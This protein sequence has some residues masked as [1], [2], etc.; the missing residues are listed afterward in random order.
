MH[1]RKHIVLLTIWFPPL[2]SVAVNRM[3]AF[4]RYL[5]HE[6]FDLT[7]I[8]LGTP[9]LHGVQEESGTQI[10]RIR[11][12]NSLWKPTFKASDSKLWHYTKVAWR[13]VRT[14]LLGDE[15]KFWSSQAS[16]ALRAL[17]QQKK[18][19]LIISSFSPIAPH[20]V[21]LAF[22]RQ[23]PQCKWIVDMRDEMSLNPQSTESERV[24]YARIEKEINQQASA[25]ISVSKPIVDYFRTVI[26]NLAHY[27]EIRNGF[28][29]DYVPPQNAPDSDCLTILHA[30]SFYGTRKP[31]TFFAALERLHVAHKLPARWRLV[32]AGAA[33]NFTIPEIFKNQVEILERVSQEESIRLMAAADLNLLVQPPTGRKGVY[34]GKIFDYLS[35]RKP[36]FAVVD[37]E[38]VAA[39]LVRELNA[40][41]VADFTNV[42]AIEEALLKAIDDWQSKSPFEPDAAKIAGLHR[43]F[44]VQKLNLLIETLLDAH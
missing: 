41:Y 14:R 36:V 1:A 27:E 19:D 38:D 42:A 10:I 28:D 20:L 5:D 21:A 44:Q 35:V 31:G 23:F 25:L 40:G 16:K 30:G 11:P 6:R 32:C 12:R 43:K 33:R 29:N 18:V 37:P 9:D 15:D 13:K 8:T 26:P 22:C 4:A 17:H 3:D 2:Q 34:T 24:Y 39:A 7:V